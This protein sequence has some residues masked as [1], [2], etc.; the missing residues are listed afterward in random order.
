MC[1]CKRIYNTKPARRPTPESSTPAVV[2]TLMFMLAPLDCDGAGAPEAELLELALDDDGVEDDPAELL[3]PG[4][5][6]GAEPGAPADEDPPVALP[7]LTEAIAFCWNAW[8][9]FSGVALMENTIPCSQWLTG[10]ERQM[11]VNNR[12]FAE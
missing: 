8:K 12:C 5:A 11:S 1:P 3:P 2:P 10:L 4:A 9:L 6:V 7:A